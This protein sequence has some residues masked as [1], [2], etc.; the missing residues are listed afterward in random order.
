MLLPDP[1]HLFP[2]PNLER[3]LVWALSRRLQPTSQLGRSERMGRG[4]RLDGDV[5]HSLWAGRGVRESAPPE[6]SNRERSGF[7]QRPRRDVHGVRNAVRV[8]KRD[9]AAAGG[10]DSIIGE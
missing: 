6:F 8:G 2:K 9:C 1:L 3:L 5:K 10:H 7:E 4:W